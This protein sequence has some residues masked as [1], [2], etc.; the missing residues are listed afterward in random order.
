MTP[1]RVSLLLLALLLSFPALA[2]KRPFTWG[3]GTDILP[4][5]D[6]E[7]EQWLWAKGRAPAN[8]AKPATGYIWWSPIFGLSEH[9]EL[10]V[11]FELKATRD[12]ANL[13]FFAVDLRYRLKPRSDQGGFQTLF[14]GAWQHSFLSGDRSRLDG[15]MIM[16]WG[17]ARE[18]FVNVDLGMQLGMP[19]L[20]GDAGPVFPVLTYDVGV[21]YPLNPEG[22]WQGGIELFGEL[23]LMLD[24]PGYAPRFGDGLSKMHH[25]AGPTVS[26]TR[27]RM[28]ATLGVL[29]GL[30]PFFPDTPI[31]MPRFMW[32]VVL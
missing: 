27:G 14:R 18:L 29:F 2:G 9:V 21:A 11:P 6:V 19:W 10:S 8:E 13:N 30:T 1:P 3:W 5:G 7:L 16:S 17:S 23:P 32:A 15:N 24:T 31:V 22:E 4:E 12:G 20:R 28:W 25:F 26:L